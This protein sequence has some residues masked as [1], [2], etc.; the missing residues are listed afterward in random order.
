MRKIIAMIEIDDDKAIKEDL[1][2]IDYL[3]REFGWLLESGIILKE[4]RILD[5]DDEYDVEAIE[6]ANKIFS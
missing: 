1:G 3:D 5:C 6:L 4:A 2:T